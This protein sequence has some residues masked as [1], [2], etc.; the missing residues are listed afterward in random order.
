MRINNQNS[1]SVNF[2]GIRT[3]TIA[4]SIPHIESAIDI[5][6]LSAK[7]DKQFIK[8]LPQKIKVQELMPDLSEFSYMRWQDMLEYASIKALEPDK[9]VLLAVVDNKPCGIEVYLPGKNNY[10]LDCICTWPVEYGKKVKLAGS[11]L[12]KE[13]FEK[14]QKS[15]A[16]RISLEAITN[17]PFDNVKKYKSLG[18]NEF[19]TVGHKVFMDTSRSNVRKTLNSLNKITDDLPSFE[20]NQVNMNKVLDF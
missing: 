8:S 11:A 1:A 14:F 18:F 13:L 10:H 4:S 15:K 2:N 9:R 12:I 6:E 7:T 5:F 20:T 3:K 19:D 16:D 17:G